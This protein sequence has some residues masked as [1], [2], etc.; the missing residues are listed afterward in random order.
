MQIGQ[1]GATRGIRI[2]DQG[3]GGDQVGASGAGDPRHQHM[4]AGTRIE[5]SP[6]SEAF[7]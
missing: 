3:K 6:A 2:Q 4:A 5:M 7:N 1:H